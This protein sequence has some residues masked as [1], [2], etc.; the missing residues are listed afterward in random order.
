MIVSNEHSHDSGADEKDAVD[1]DPGVLV[2]P[3]CRSELGDGRPTSSWSVP[4]GQ[5]E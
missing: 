3:S 5:R 2:R 1:M 4:W